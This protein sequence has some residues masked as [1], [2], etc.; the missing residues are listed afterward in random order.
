M[1][2]FKDAAAHLLEMA[3][4]E[5]EMEWTLGTEVVRTVTDMCAG[6]GEA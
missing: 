1:A 2:C 5:A 6:S 4:P 3:G